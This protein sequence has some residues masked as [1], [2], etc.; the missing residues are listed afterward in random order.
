MPLGDS[1][2]A[3][4]D[5]PP[6]FSTSAPTMDSKKWRYMRCQDRKNHEPCWHWFQYF[7]CS[8]LDGIESLALANGSIWR[9]YS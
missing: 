5:G 6:S 9:T 2:G 3:Q 1:T 4:S 7:F 8:A